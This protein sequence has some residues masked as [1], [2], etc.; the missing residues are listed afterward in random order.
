MYGWAR[1]K[2][3]VPGAMAA[4]GRARQAERLCMGGDGNRSSARDEAGQVEQ[5]SKRR[6]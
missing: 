6:G 4:T 2:D 5:A 1:G 3:E